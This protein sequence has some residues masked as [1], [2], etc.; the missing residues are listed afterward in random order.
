MNK[1]KIIIGLITLA[2]MVGAYLVYSS[3]VDTPNIVMNETDPEKEEIDVPDFDTQSGS[4]GGDLKIAPVGVS[5]FV[6]R[7][8]DTKKVKSV[9]GFE[10][11]LNP[12][13]GTDLWRL[14]KPYMKMFE[15]KFRCDIT[16]DF[17][18]VRVE[19]VLNVPT[20]V[21]AELTENVEILIEMTDD[22]KQFKICLDN[23]IYDNERSE[24]T[25]DGPVTLLSENG[26]MKGKG[27]ILLYDA[28]VS[29]LAYLEIT[30]LEYLLL[31]NVRSSDIDSGQ[32]DSARP[33]VVSNSD[34]P[35]AVASADLPEQ[36]ADSINPVSDTIAGGEAAVL[37]PD[38]MYKYYQCSL[39]KKVNIE[40]GKKIVVFGADEVI[41][42]NI[43]WSNDRKSAKSAES[44]KSPEPETVDSSNAA[45][46]DSSD[47]EFVRVDDDSAVAAASLD[48]V[49][50]DKTDTKV[51]Q[52]LHLSPT[53]PA[54]ADIPS[55][56]NVRHGDN[57]IY[58]TCDGSLIIRPMELA[59]LKPE[60][61]NAD[62]RRMRIK[63]RPV[64]VGQPVDD[65]GRDIETIASCGLMTYDIDAEVLDLE[66][67]EAGN[68]IELK[69]ARKDASILTE[70]SVRWQRKANHAVVVGPGMMFLSDDDDSQ[71]AESPNI[72][73]DG[74]MDVYF[75]D[76][77]A[78]S[79][80][81]YL[82]VSRVNL[83][84]NVTF[85]SARGTVNSDRAEV[86]FAA[87]DSGDNVPVT[88]TGSGNAVLEPAMYNGPQPTRFHAK[89]I[90]YDVISGKAVA[91][92]PVKFIFYPNQAA[93]GS[94]S[95]QI[96]VVITAE[97]NAKYFPEAN[98]VVFS[99]DVVGTRVTNDIDIVR[100]E[101]IKGGNL[102]VD[103]IK[104]EGDDPQDEIKHIRVSGGTVT[105]RTQR[106]MDNYELSDI[107]MSC[108]QL[109][110]GAFDNTVIAE[111]PGQIEIDNANAAETDNSD[112]RF[113]LDGP[114]KALIFGFATLAWDLNNSWLKAD[115]GNGTVNVSYLPI[116]DGQMQKNKIVKASA[117]SIVCDLEENAEGRFELAS[118]QT[119][120][121]IF[122]EETGRHSIIGDTMHY[123]SD[124]GI[125][126][127][128]GADGQPCYV[129]GRA[130]TSYIEYN[131]QTGAITSQLSR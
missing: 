81:K 96:P 74:L 54:L 110:W 35:Q 120:D 72:K 59:G 98:Q 12:Q 57:D 3:F 100:H 43:L 44:A 23:L 108:Q 99:G 4:M 88:V 52:D 28:Q 116:E 68:F 95:A 38:Q 53:I 126:K 39:D 106:T 69:M 109:D 97:D 128:K 83:G 93:N 75:A 58:I 32:N 42:S 22:G 76:V 29:K 51:P 48:T 87:N 103:L 73:F 24:F 105:L 61:L 119:F 50:G 122:Y 89:I 16:S 25:S 66:R 19:F 94:G 71:S 85:N 125:M 5:E 18:K 34:A 63:G 77:P 8:D 113:N 114:C 121:G 102:I 127:I 27:L 31:K 70:G 21:T 45:G 107:S 92:G 91:T 104:S 64:R 2:V 37:S 118:M 55:V 82:A 84:G 13:A 86:L 14:Q 20:P 131:L 40:Y 49:S 17:G 30:D 33:A 80:P 46:A 41:I 47:I 7:D 123:S 11:M 112:G 111:G 36:S 78:P 26:I 60:R 9:L 117:G 62:S 129:D 124:T 79:E 6:T 90:E 65:D 10:Q 67:G 101:T 1:R 56:S 115:G 15:D 130:R